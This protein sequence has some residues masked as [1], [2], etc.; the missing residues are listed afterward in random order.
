MSAPTIKSFDK[1]YDAMLALSHFRAHELR[2]LG[3]SHHD[4]RSKAHDL[5]TLP[6]RELWGRIMVP[7]GVAD[8]ARE[9]HGSPIRILSAYRSPAYNKAVG[10]AKY[11]RHLQF[12]A[13]DLCPMDGR[14][15]ALVRTLKRLR[16]EGHFTGGIGVYPSFVHID[17]RGSNVDF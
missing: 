10:G 9:L 15:M 11:S 14:V 6:P 16:R 4:P 12:D 3:G 7:A 1:W 5:N 8:M 2:F 17:N 13:L